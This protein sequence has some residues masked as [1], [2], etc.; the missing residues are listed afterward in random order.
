MEDIFV[1]RC[2]STRL[3]SALSILRMGSVMYSQ[4]H[5]DCYG[6]TG[7]ITHVVDDELSGLQ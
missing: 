2:S 5:K 1:C 7:N 3:C 4:F 6:G